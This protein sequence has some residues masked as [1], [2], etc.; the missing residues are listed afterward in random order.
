MSRKPSYN[1]SRHCADDSRPLHIRIRSLLEERVTSGRYPVGTL[2]PTEVELAREF[3]TSRFTIRE[4]LRY[5][6]ERGYVERR[7]GVGTRVI[8]QG[9]QANYTLSVRSLEELFQV[10]RGTR[11]EII[12][13]TRLTL[14]ASEA[15]MLG[16]TEGEEWLRLDGLRW[17]SPGGEPLCFVQVHIPAVFASLMPEIRALRGPIFALIERHADGPIERTEQ[18]IN[19]MP[20]PPD[21]AER[22]CGA[23]EAWALRL[24]RRYV[25]R[26]GVIVA[27]VNWHPA[28][29]MTY[30]M[31]IRRASPGG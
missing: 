31:E 20:M 8:S 9:A 24:V 12:G 26:Q 6:H 2:L 19:A 25:T 7:Q 21:M 15:E 30:T 16:G 4:A 27:S 14:N 23:R 10:A 17:T 5:L 3:D 28:A 11:L 22:L 1:G 29:E 18:D 13:E